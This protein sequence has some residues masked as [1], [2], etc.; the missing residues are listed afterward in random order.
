MD[1]ELH[2]LTENLFEVSFVTYKFT[3]NTH[4]VLQEAY[5]MVDEAKGEKF[6]V[7]KRLADA[8]GQVS[9]HGYLKE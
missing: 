6:H 3:I 8:T 9:H 5:K 1:D 4:N 2:T 7:E